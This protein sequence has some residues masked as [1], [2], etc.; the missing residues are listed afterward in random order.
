[1][2]KTLTIYTTEPCGHCRTAKDIL[3]RHGISYEE[4]N[5]SKDPDGR[6]ELARRTGLM[7]FPQI[8]IGEEPLG[9]AREL[10]AAASSGRLEDL[11][12]A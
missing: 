10:Y 7:T 9:G 12:A 6:A 8:I 2:P 11:L 4:I 5:L 1:M 3:G